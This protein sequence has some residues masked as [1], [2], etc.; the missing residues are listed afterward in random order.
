MSALIDGIPPQ[1][2]K[3]LPSGFQRDLV[4]KSGSIATFAPRYYAAVLDSQNQSENVLLLISTMKQDTQL[5]PDIREFIKFC[6]ERYTLQRFLGMQRIYKS[7]HID[8]IQQF[9]G[10]ENPEMVLNLVSALPQKVQYDSSTR[11][12]IFLPRPTNSKK[13]EEFRYN[14]RSELDIL[15]RT[16]QLETSRESQIPGNVYL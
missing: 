7:V 10:L 1:L 5:D 6:G 15:L 4:A 3:I 16:I 11:M 14:Q 8:R 12:A 9:L 2:P 13:H